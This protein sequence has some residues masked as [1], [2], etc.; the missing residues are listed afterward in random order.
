MKRTYLRT[1]EAF[2][3]D[4]ATLQRQ[5]HNAVFTQIARLLEDGDSLVRSYDRYI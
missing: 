2:N 1:L 5:V 4:V 3:E